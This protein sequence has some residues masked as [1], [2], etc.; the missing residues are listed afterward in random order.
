MFS[1]FRSEVFI[2]TCDREQ[3]VPVDLIKF[4]IAHDD[5]DHDGLEDVGAGVAYAAL[6]LQ[7]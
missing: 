5:H 4:I 3:S 6:Y 1:L 7:I 2:G